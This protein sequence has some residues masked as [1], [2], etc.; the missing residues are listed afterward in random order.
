MQKGNNMSY[1]EISN[2]SFFSR[3]GSSIKGIIFGIIIFILAFPLL[4]WNEGRAVKRYKALK[5]GSGAVISVKA[6]TVDPA[7]EGKLVHITALATTKDILEDSEFGI[8]A[9][10]IKLKRAVQMYQWKEIQKSEKT[11]KVGGG[12]T[13]ETTYTYEKEW[14]SK[15]IDSGKFKESQSHTNPA[16]MT[17]E[18][19]E[20][21]AKNVTLSAFGLSGTLVRKIKNYEDVN[22]KGSASE[23]PEAL[24]DKAQIANNNFYIGAN[25]DSPKIGD[26]K[27]SFQIVN[28]SDVTIVS[29]QTGATFE[30]YITKG[31]QQIELLRV[32]TFSADSMFEA[33]KKENATITWVLR[34]LGFG[35]MFIGSALVLRPFS[36]VA[37]VI[38]FIGNIVGAGIALVSLVMALVF[39]F[40]TISIAWIV[41]RPLLG[42][43]LLVVAGALIF[44][45][46]KMPKKNKQEQQA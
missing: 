3:I 43:L 26:T 5:E 18:N 8:S 4:F 16:V 19:K 15:L 14:S 22:L 37:D 42:I 29:S 12:T 10:A 9:N 45:L 7:N 23:L 32:G 6:D 2:Q 38:P 36:V 39:S 40:I 28:P 24:K 20:Y 13:T 31:N 33:A 25:P 44:G 34:F 1:T 46:K 27:V 41:Y 21:I 11:K 30:P 17:Y 35:L